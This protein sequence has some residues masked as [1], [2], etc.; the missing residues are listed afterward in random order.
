[1]TGLRLV[2]ALG[3]LLAIG[4]PVVLPV[5][6]L[7]SEPSAW[8]AWQE[9]GRLAQLWKNTSLLVGGTLLL[10]L[11]VG[12]VAALLCYRTDLP[13]RRLFRFLII[14]SLFV[15]L[16][17]FASAWQAALGSDGWLPL[18]VWTT[19]PV[20]D[21]DVVAAGLT[22]KPWAQGLPAAIW[23]HAVAA[24]PW[25]IMIVGQGVRWGE[26]ELE[27][28]GLTAAGPGRVLW[29]VTLPRCR[30]AIGAAALWIAI[31]T[32]TE[33]TVTDMFQVRTFAEEV[34]YQFVLGDDA[35]AARGVAVALPVVLLT[36]VC[37]LWIMARLPRQ[38]SRLPSTEP[39][40]FVLGRL[41]W[42]CCALAVGFAAVL[43]G[44]PLAGLVWKL[45]L[46]GTPPSWHARE[47]ARALGHVYSARS[48]MIA[49]SL[50]W[51]VSAGAAT[52][53]V[54]LASSWLALDSRWFRGGILML[55]TLAWSLPGPVLGLG[56][57]A[58]IARAMDGEDAVAEVIGVGK[59]HFVSALLYEGSSPAPIMWTSLVR[60][61][62]FAVVFLWPFFRQLPSEWRE[63][64]RLEGVRP[65]QEFRF[66]IWPLFL[67]IT[68]QAMLGVAILSLGEVSAGKLAETPGT[69]TFA[70][71]L[72]NQMHYGVKNDL[73]ALA[74]ILLLLV[75]T[76][77][78][79]LAC[80]MRRLRRISAS[81]NAP[82]P[83]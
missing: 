8:Q 76:G 62:P 66:L 54:A 16:P 67:P 36:A 55:V 52:G 63:L 35:A 72:F 10:A 7:G 41:R 23:I 38:W 24:L 44:V 51:A 58:A 21:P 57:K 37:L 65:P 26:T 45:G 13:G 49:A 53:M 27:E 39:R 43:I 47:A 61:L 28:D 71:E 19:P 12:I 25:V 17:L 74:L 73:A 1:M 3:L 32:A 50:L 22:W 78:T 46:G 68:A 9:W 33:I 6:E 60:F 79:A 15:P 30:V 75:T 34:Y 59:T 82:S 11:P 14:L 2:L 70:H 81:I 83:S 69:Q 29:H 5:L 40:P 31:Q 64:A 77:A 48:G 42:P 20:D 80:S 56:I 4:V 18:G